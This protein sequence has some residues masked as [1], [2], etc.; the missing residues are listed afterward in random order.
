MIHTRVQKID[1]E[2]KRGL[3]FVAS[4]FVCWCHFL[5]P[6][7]QINVND[8]LPAPHPSQW[9]GGQWRNSISQLFVDV[10]Y[11]ISKKCSDMSPTLRVRRATVARGDAA[12]VATL[13]TISSTSHDRPRDPLGTLP[14]KDWRSREWRLRKDARS[15]AAEF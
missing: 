4:N 15:R 8:T 10:R 6:D 3:K 7:K 12:T 1:N 5:T 11:L 13:C 9:R 14:T 2:M